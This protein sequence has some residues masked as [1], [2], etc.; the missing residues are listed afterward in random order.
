MYK[1]K[2]FNED[3]NGETA[4]VFGET[5]DPL[6][7]LMEREGTLDD[8]DIAQQFTNDTQVDALWKNADKGTDQGEW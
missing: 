5:A 8:G 3:Y 2:F 6:L 4:V 1:A 7:I